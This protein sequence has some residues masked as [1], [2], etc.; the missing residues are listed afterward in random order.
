MKS[1]SY[2]ANFVGAEALNSQLNV[3]CDSL[4]VNNG[5][6]ALRISFLLKEIVWGKILFNLR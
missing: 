6:T 4:G 3:L 2:Y 5:K 1:L